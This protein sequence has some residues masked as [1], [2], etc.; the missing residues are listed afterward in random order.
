MSEEKTVRGVHVGQPFVIDLEGMPGAGYMW[1][2]ASAPGEIELLSQEVVS[3]SKAIGGSSTQR[4]QF[5][6]RQPGN[7]ALVFGLKRKWEKSPVETNEFLIRA[8]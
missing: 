8:E 1:E 4:F 2:L 5:V 6:A 7:H 3:I